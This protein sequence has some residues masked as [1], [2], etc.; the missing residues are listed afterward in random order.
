MLVHQLGLAEP[1]VFV[2]MTAGMALI[3]R[4]KASEFRVGVGISSL[5]VDVEVYGNHQ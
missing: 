2:G 4:A 5:R 3:W 1:G